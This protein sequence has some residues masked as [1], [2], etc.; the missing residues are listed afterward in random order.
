MPRGAKVLV[1]DGEKAA[2]RETVA[3]IADDGGDAAFHRLDG[4]EYDAFHAIVGDVDEEYE[5]DCLVNN[6]GVTQETEFRQTTLTERDQLLSVNLLSVWNRC[7]VAIPRFPAGDAIVNVSS[8]GAFDGFPNATT[9]ALCKAA[10]SN[11]TKSLA[12]L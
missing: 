10:V 12:V 8:V 5:L 1:T 7:H 3:S 9:Y 6:A 2:S 11:L 4:T